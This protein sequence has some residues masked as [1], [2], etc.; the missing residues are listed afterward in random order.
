MNREGEDREVMAADF[1]IGERVVN[2]WGEDLG[3]IEEIVID[4]EMGR[5]RYAVLSFGGVFG[6][7][8]KLFALPW[9][10]LRADPEN[11][12]FV[13]DID[14]ERL[15]NA[16]GFDRHDWPRMADPQWGRDIHRFYDQTPYWEKGIERPGF[17]GGEPPESE[18][19]PRHE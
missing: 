5:V 1:L 17:F 8:E 3:K 11:R 2:S 19:K 10:V 14:R 18:R 12:Q 15:K 6:L 16:P 13:L 7:G 9:K 4:V